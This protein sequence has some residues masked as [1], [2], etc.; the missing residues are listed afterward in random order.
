MPDTP[1]Q[2]LCAGLLGTI[3]ALFGFALPTITITLFLAALSFLV[4]LKLLDLFQARGLRVA[5]RGDRRAPWLWQA[6]LAGAIAGLGAR[7]LFG[8]AA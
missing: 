3:S 4:S 1:T 2:W 5:R 6:P 7:W 8:G